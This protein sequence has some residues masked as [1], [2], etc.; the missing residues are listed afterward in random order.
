M[1]PPGKDPVEDIDGFIKGWAYPATIHGLDVA[2]QSEGLE[3]K[4]LRSDAI[5]DASSAFESLSCTTFPPLGVM[6]SSS[7]IDVDVDTLD[8][9]S[10]FNARLDALCAG[11]SLP[12][13]A[14]LQEVTGAN[15]GAGVLFRINYRR[16]Q[17]LFPLLQR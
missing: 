13:P 8:P 14:N 7:P 3:S 6:R 10:N 5:Q 15:C 9:S 4:V 2:I 1:I 17:V 16:I 12:L 11:L